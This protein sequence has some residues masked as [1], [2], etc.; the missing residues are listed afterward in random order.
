MTDDTTTTEPPTR[1]KYMKYG[2]AVVGGG[3]LTGCTG[4]SDAGATPED[5]QTGTD[6]STEETESAD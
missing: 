6:T 1:R 3:L 4:D 2:G 5:T